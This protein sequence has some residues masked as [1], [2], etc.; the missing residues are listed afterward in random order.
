MYACV[1]I[2]MS[3]FIH[4]QITFSPDDLIKPRDSPQFSVVVCACESLL[5][6]II[7]TV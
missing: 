4:E 3:I 2:T 1:H 7:A 5:F 6:V